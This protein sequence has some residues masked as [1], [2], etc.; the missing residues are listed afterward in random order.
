[1]QTTIQKTFIPQKDVMA[2]LGNFPRNF[3]DCVVIRSTFIFLLVFPSQCCTVW[4]GQI[5]S[6]YLNEE[7]LFL[8]IMPAIMLEASHKW[9]AGPYDPQI[10]IKHAVIVVLFTDEINFETQVG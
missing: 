10:P 1:M 2:F 5:L 6:H 3:L 7:E 8:F 4:M 9:A